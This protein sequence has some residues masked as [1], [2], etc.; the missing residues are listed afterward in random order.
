M[1]LLS[2]R[3]KSA[4]SST[5]AAAEARR[6]TP[7]QARRQLERMLR[8]REFLVRPRIMR[9]LRYFVEASIQTGFEPINQRLIATQALGL[10]D[11]FNPNLS[12][13]VRVNIA[14]LRKAIDCYYAGSGRH[15]PLVF[16]ITRGPYRLIAARITPGTDSVTPQ[17]AREA[18]RSRPLLLVVEPDVEGVKDADGE[19][20]A[21]AIGV[22]LACQLV[23]S[24]LVTVSGPL[25]RDRVAPGEASVADAAAM[26]GYDYV[27]DATIRAV[28]TR[29]SVRLAVVD[30][31]NGSAIDQAADTL[32]PCADAAEVIDAIAA[33]F[34][35]RIGDCF[36]SRT[37]TPEDG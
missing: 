17:A 26:L 25:A 30:T 28:G 8:S 32:G 11:D 10:S 34:F 22:R 15:D 4:A 5:A 1:S 2:S 9:L 20:L 19:P 18:R 37:A 3:S 33:W 16:E 14:R 7:A 35:H 12:A 6:A 21:R 27:A 31:E 13:Y 24:T 36:A 29:W 23:E